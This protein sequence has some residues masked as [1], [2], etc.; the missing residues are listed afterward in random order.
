MFGSG[1]PSKGP[2]ERRLR[3]QDRPAD[4]EHV[5][6]AAERQRERRLNLGI[7]GDAA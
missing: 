1:R 7:A 5:V 3:P 6:A 2:R 4:G